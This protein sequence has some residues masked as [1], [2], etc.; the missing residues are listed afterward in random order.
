MSVDDSDVSFIP[1]FVLSLCI[2]RSILLSECPFFAARTLT[3][4]LIRVVSSL[5][6][7]C[8]SS[9]PSLSPPERW[10]SERE[11]RA[12]SPD[13]W[14]RGMVGVKK[15]VRQSVITEKIEQSA[16]AP[17]AADQISTGSR[18]SRVSK[19][20]KGFGKGRGNVATVVAENIVEKIVQI[21]RKVIA[22]EMAQ[23]KVRDEMMVGILRKQKLAAS[24]EQALEKA[25]ELKKTKLA[26]EVDKV[27]IV[28]IEK[29]PAL[30]VDPAVEIVDKLVPV[31]KEVV[32]I[33]KKKISEKKKIVDRKEESFT[34]G[35]QSVPVFEIIKLAAG[36]TIKEGGNVRVGPP[37]AHSAVANNVSVI[38]DTVLLA[39]SLTRKAYN[40]MIDSIQSA[41]VQSLLLSEELL[42]DIGQ[43][44][45]E[46]IVKKDA[47]QP[48]LDRTASSR[49]DLLKSLSR[50]QTPQKIIYPDSG[51]ERYP[52]EGGASSKFSAVE[53]YNEQLITDPSWGSNP[54]ANQTTILSPI[55][56]KRQ[57]SAG[58][59][60]KQSRE[61]PFVS[62]TATSATQRQHLPV[63]AFPQTFGHG[64]ISPAAAISEKNQKNSEPMSSIA[65]FPS[66][67]KTASI[68]EERAAFSTAKSKIT[69]TN[70]SKS[71]L[72]KT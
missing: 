67:S 16:L 43:Q 70:L 19:M 31:S 4:Q 26:K 32:G 55:L 56:P 7:L 51:T 42:E 23:D 65:F 34:V 41:P 6:P 38:S 21:E 40:E 68:R 22:E 3:P 60:S 69:L 18:A 52:A 9:S 35:A 10:E 54:Q 39:K 59:I 61:R 46:N 15:R 71:L 12:Q 8:G 13:R 57:V 14:N 64:L 20:N 2:H 30:I 17:K 62:P 72:Q 58:K 27:A 44:S 29:L 36:V 1:N 25:E 45:K 53:L 66:S 63:P 24:Q 48:K 49:A 37:P 11:P 50:P 47:I 33:A 28:S 5:F